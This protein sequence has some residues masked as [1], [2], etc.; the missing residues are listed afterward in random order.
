MVLRQIIIQIDK[1]VN[2]NIKSL[3]NIPSK[4]RSQNFKIKYKIRTLSIGKKI[5]ENK[6]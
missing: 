1:N 6:G 2:F 3:I 5:N 4:L